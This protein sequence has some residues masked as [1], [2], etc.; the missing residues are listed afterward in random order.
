MQR[1]TS[2]T[3]HFS[4]PELGKDFTFT[5]ETVDGAPKIVTLTSA[6]V[7]TSPV[8]NVKIID[9]DGT[10]VGYMQYNAFEVTAQQPL[11]N[12]FNQLSAANVDEII[13]DL[14]YNGGGLVLAVCTS[15]L[16][17]GWY[18]FHLHVC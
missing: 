18:A 15:W 2:S 5:F 7:A 13:M 1:L 14:R 3:R 11:I 12:A 16:H 10:K 8:R 17:A 9:N 4:P 6:D